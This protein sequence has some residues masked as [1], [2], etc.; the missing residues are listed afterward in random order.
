MTDTSAGGGVLGASC[1]HDVSEQRRAAPAIKSA[2][3]VMMEVGMRSFVNKI[4]AK[5]KSRYGPAGLSAQ[6]TSAG[7]RRGSFSAVADVDEEAT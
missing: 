1:S 7:C 4:S 6:S 2:L 3:R 5:P